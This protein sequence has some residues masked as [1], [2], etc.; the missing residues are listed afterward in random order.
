[1]DDESCPALFLL[2]HGSYSDFPEHIIRGLIPASKT[3]LCTMA[4]LLGTYEVKTIAMLFLQ[5]SSKRAGQEKTKRPHVSQ[6]LV[7]ASDGLSTHLKNM[8]V[9]NMFLETHLL[10]R[11]FLVTSWSPYERLPLGNP[12]PLGTVA[13]RPGFC[14]G[15]EWTDKVVLAQNITPW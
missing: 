2:A 9:A 11:L 1:M 13:T 6:V 12:G 8:K 7:C 5:Q 15:G 4:Q 3:V 10:S 14:G